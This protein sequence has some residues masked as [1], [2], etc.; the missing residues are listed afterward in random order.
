MK[1]SYTA[2]GKDNQKLTGTLTADSLEMA[3]A[4]LHKMDLSI[5]IL[6]E[7]KEPTTPLSTFE[8][9]KASDLKTEIKRP[10]EIITYYFV[11][12]DPQGKEVN[13]TIDSN[14]AY[15]AYKRLITEY[16]FEVIEMQIYQSAEG[17]GSSLKSNFEEW[18][19]KL[20]E[21][22][23]DPHPK[24]AASSVKNELEDEGEKMAVEIVT[25]IDH[26][27]LNTKKI[28]AEHSQQYS[29]VFLNEIQASLG[30]LERIR[31]SNNL[32]H[33]T[34]VCHDLY[35]LISHPDLNSKDPGGDAE[36]QDY[37][38]MIENLKQSGFVENKS[39]FLN[40]TDLK[41]RAEG[42][43]GI[44][45]IFSKIQGKLNQETEEL[46]AYTA[47]AKKPSDPSQK[48][49]E[50]SLRE[51]G[52]KYFH[53]LSERNPILKRARKQEFDQA[54]A[55]RKSFKNKLNLDRK[56]LE[57]NS[58]VF[59]TEKDF[60]GFFMELNSFVGWLLFFYL[61][62]FFLA[63]FSL[64]RNLGLSQ[65]LVVKTLSSPL[66]INISIFLLMAHLTLTL[67]LRVFRK[68]WMG[69]TFLFFFSMAIYMV[70][71]ANL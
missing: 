18:N 32:N 30:N 28:I 6:N 63:S 15:L 35:E 25:E 61:F 5:L 46:E 19:I 11:G 27:I 34:K 33:I 22:G 65:A 62:Y 70:L 64:E 60:S 13:G 54:W 24:K 55:E 21:E 50:H 68:N 10:V 14:D 67:K 31:S 56:Q 58:V 42:F 8:S 66:V 43:K 45:G 9:P 1:F 40:P 7:A 53:F 52:V 59:K 12:R 37:Q 36:N 49:V 3:Q 47:E 44:K 16:K 26:F 71:M 38:R 57:E 23:I 69:T 39:N 29:K 20:Q 48:A 41:K 51:L 17:D 4:E 2:L